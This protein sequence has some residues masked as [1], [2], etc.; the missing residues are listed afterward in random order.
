ML[1][2]D[3]KCINEMPVMYLNLD[4]KV[5]DDVLEIHDFYTRTA[6]SC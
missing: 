2:N 5:Q 6:C 1:K 4:R 3:E